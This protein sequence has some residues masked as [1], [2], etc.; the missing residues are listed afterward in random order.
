M[1]AS[2]GCVLGHLSCSPTGCALAPRIVVCAWAGSLGP[3]EA[4]GHP[5]PCHLLLPWQPPFLPSP[6]LPPCFETP[7]PLH[8]PPSLRSPPPKEM[9]Q[10]NG[11]GVGLPRTPGLTM[12]RHGMPEKL[13]SFFK[14]PQNTN[15][16]IVIFFISLA[17]NLQTAFFLVLS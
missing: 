2:H 15:V 3:R 7:P 17:I 8:L 10:R 12:L 13:E 5:G 9:H 1:S 14:T 4:L 16:K 11:S 6:L